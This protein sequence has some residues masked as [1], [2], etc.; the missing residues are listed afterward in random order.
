MI[1]NNGDRI[2]PK[3][4]GWLASQYDDV[5]SYGSDNFVRPFYLTDFQNFLVNI[6]FVIQ[7]QS[8]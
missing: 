1:G 7:A 4:H 2:P 3:W 8:P 6:W 5:P